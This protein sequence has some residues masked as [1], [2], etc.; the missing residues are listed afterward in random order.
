MHTATSEE[1]IMFCNK[2]HLDPNEY[3]EVR[4]LFRMNGGIEVEYYDSD[5]EGRKFIFQFALVGEWHH[6]KGRFS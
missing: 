1:A 2:A 4:Y 5:G 6:G 3:K